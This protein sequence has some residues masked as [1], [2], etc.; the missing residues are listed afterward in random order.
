MLINAMKGEQLLYFAILDKNEVNPNIVRIAVPYTYLD[1]VIESLDLSI[2]LISIAAF[3]VAL[4]ASTLA[5][6]YTYRNLSELENAI[7]SLAN[8]PTKRKALKALPTERVNEFGN[9]ARSISQIS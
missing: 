7:L 2:L 6:N 8:A 5:S 1:K 9:V 3:I 4:L